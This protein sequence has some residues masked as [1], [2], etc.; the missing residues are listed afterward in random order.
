MIT[1][2]A[3]DLVR[4]LAHRADELAPAVRRALVRTTAA[5]QRFAAL[6]QAFRN[7]TGRLRQSIGRGERS[8]FDHFI[9][10]GGPSA[11]YALFVEEGTRPHVIRARRAKALRFYQGGELRFARSV[12]HPGTK[13]AHF[14]KD[15]RD[16]AEPEFGIFL[17]NALRPLFR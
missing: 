1:F 15:A 17:E 5:A 6:T 4:E 3:G 11:R 7:Q 10:A 8:R 16:R 9:R 12:N 2:D 13:P 14:M